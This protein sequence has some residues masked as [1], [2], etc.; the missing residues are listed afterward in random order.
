MKHPCAKSAFTLASAL[1]VMSGCGDD[2]AACGNTRN[3]SAGVQGTVSLCPEIDAYTVE[4]TQ[5][6]I[7]RE[8][9]LT[10]SAHDAGGNPLI[11][12]WQSSAGTVADGHA[13]STTFT[14]TAPGDVT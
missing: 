11:F 13:A 3:G 4:P 9:H 8:V 2:P 1:A 10:A 7:G 6:A 5:L 12:A 14:C